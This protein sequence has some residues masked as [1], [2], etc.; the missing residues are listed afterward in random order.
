MQVPPPPNK[1]SMQSFFRKINFMR[2]FILD[3]AEIVKPLQH[4]IKKDIQFKW[5]FVEKEAF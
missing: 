4:M 5:K 2:R 1:N 3:F